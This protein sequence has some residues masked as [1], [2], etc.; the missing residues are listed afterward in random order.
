M[1]N[2]CT[3]CQTQNIPTDKKCIKCGNKLKFAVALT[4][5]H[6]IKIYALSVFFAPFGLYWVRKHW[7]SEYPQNRRVAKIALLIT[8]ALIGMTFA[9]GAYYVSLVKEQMDYYNSIGL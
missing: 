3:K 9:M 5:A 2:I 4:R 7:S 6:E 1:E 8:I